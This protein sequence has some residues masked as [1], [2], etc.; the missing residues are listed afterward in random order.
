MRQHH[1]FFAMRRFGAAI[2][3]LV[4]TLSPIGAQDP[5]PKRPAEAE[6]LHAILLVAGA[7]E[8]I[9]NADLHDVAA[10]RHIL[11]QTL[12]G[13]ANQLVIHD[14]TGKNPK[15]KKFYSGPEILKF[16][17]GLKVGENDNVLIFHSGHGGIEDRKKP[18]ES[19]VLFVDGGSINRKQLTKAAQDLKPRAVIMLT[20]CCSSYTSSVALMEAAPPLNKKSVRNLMLRPVGLVSVTAAEDGTIA[21]AN[22]RGE[23]PADAGSAF[24]VA[25]TRLWYNTEVTYTSWR[26]FFPKLRDETRT[27]SGGQ[28]RAR[29]FHLGEAPPKK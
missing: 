25:L 18:E 10:M 24:T 3:L 20:D 2:I 11:E 23:N 26:Q 12:G 16:V 21:Q 27:A 7:D 29:A 4:L 19:H 28:H 1:D 14:L 5:T 15:T 8:G 22:Y 17:E 6:K 13:K 9:G